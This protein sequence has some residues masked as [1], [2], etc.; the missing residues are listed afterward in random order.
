MGVKSIL[1][2]QLVN[3]GT[4]AFNYDMDFVPL[5]PFL[6]MTTPAYNALNDSVLKSRTSTLPIAGSVPANPSVCSAGCV[7]GDCILNTCACYAGYSGA[8]C[9]IYTPISQQN[10]IGVNL[11]GI[12][13]WSTQNPFIDL[14][15]QGSEWVY[16]ITNQGWSS[17]IAFKNQVPLDADGYPTSLPPGI[18][19]G[20]LMARDVLTH[21][22]PGNYTILYDGDGILSFGLQDVT[23]VYYGVG[24]C[25]ITVV[26]STAFNNGILVTIERTN[27][28]NYIRNIRVIRPG[29]ENAWWTQTYSPLLLEKL[30]PFGTI[31]Y[32]DWTNTNA[33]TD[34]EWNN[35]TLPSARTYTTNGVAW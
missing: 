25:V 34:T 30:A 1:F 20:T 11:Q 23:K 13:Y 8:D 22:D 32:M 5:V 29:F 21:Y 9:S 4:P 28:N 3:L 6:N 15:R 12:S 33:Q 14:H 31:R 2:S 7:W 35:R 17:G 16:F 27:P 10:K 26:P 18:S 24:K 19:V